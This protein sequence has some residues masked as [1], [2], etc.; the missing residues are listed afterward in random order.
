MTMLLDPAT[1]HARHIDIR[2]TYDGSPMT[3]AQDYRRYRKART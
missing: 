2:T 3:I 1:H